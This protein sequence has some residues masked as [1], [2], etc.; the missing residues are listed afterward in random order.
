MVLLIHEPPHVPDNKGVLGDLQLVSQLLSGFR[1][2]GKLFRLNG[3]GYNGDLASVKAAVPIHP[4]PGDFSAAKIVRGKQLVP[5]T[6]HV[7]EKAL[8]PLSPMCC[9]MIVTDSYRYPCS[10]RCEESEHRHGV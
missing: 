9:C 7:L 4:A 3:V 1:V 10:P 5:R 6:E 8:R 2:E